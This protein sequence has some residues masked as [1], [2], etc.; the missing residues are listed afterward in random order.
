MV[1]IARASIDKSLIT[2]ILM[3]GCLFGGIWGFATIGRLEDPSFSIKTAIVITQYPGA[4]AEEVA[5][6]VSEPLESAIQQ[7]AE[8][9]SISSTNTRGMSRI[10][11]DVDMSYGPDEIPQIWDKLRDRVRDA[12][13]SLPQD[14]AEPFVNDAFGDVFGLFYAVSA[15]GFSDAEIH[16]VSTFIRRE[17]LVVDGVA[18][19]TLDGLPEE[20]IH[21]EPDLAILANMGLPSSAISEAIASA[22]NLAPAGSVMRSG[23]QT[24][25]SSPRGSDTVEEI[26]TLTIGL[27]GQVVSVQ[28]FANVSRGRVAA[29]TKLIRYQGE[30]VFTLGVSALET[31]N[32]VDVGNRV[33]AR[34]DEIMESLPYGI[35]IHPIYQQ[36]VVVDEASNDFLVNLA[37][38]VLIV[39]VV[40]GLF[41]GWRA[42][43]VVG[44]TLLLTVVGTS[45]FMAIFSIE[46]QRISLGALI[47][48]MGMLVDNAIVVAEGMQGDMAGGK[49][50]RDAAKDVAGKTQIPLLGATVIGI[51]AF[52]GIGLS[53]DAT[54]EFLFSLFAV[55]GISLL[56]SWL[57]AVTV[58]PLLGHYLF[59]QGDGTQGDGYDGMVFRA[60]KSLLRRALGLRWLVVTALIVMTVLSII[61]FGRVTQQFFPPSNTPIFFVHYKLPQGSSLAATA[62]DLAVVEDWLRERP[63][64]VSASTFVGGGASRFMLTYQAEDP[65][66]SYGQVI[67]RT[68]NT[69]VILGL[70]G[71]LEA[72]G[73]ANLP[74]GQFRTEQLVFGPGGGTP[75]QARFSGP[76]PV[77]LRRLGAEAR[78]LMIAHGTDLRNI[79]HDW[80]EQEMVMRPDYATNRA[81]AAGITREDVADTLQMA[82]EGRSVAV[83]QEGA[84][85]IPIVLRSPVP[86]GDRAARLMDEL[87]YSE[88]SESYFPI[89]QV[90]DGFIPEVQ[91]SV[92]ERRDRIFTL[93]VQAGVGPGVN[94]AD[95]LSQI[96]PHLE[97]MS[98]PAGY[99][100]EWGGEYENQQD[101]QAALG[102]VLPVTLLA[103]VLTSVLLFGKL[104]Q[105]LIIWLLVPMAINGTVIALLLTGMPFSFTALLG[106]LSLSGMLI[107]NG[108][109]LVEEIDIVRGEGVPMAEAILQASTSR[110]RPVLLAAATTILGMI[111]LLSDAFFS[112]MAVTIMGGLGF[113][114]I[115]TLIAAPVLY[116][117]FFRKERLGYEKSR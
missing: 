76:D 46:M 2:W 66:P 100:F 62:A 4:S 58:T 83:Y 61:G 84:R 102:G 51:L 65:S 57:L 110:V 101:A 77:V 80:F 78:N 28:D 56:L 10:T 103:M 88:P 52:S 26:S 45:F 9:D 16:D 21:V 87:V 106:L 5:R 35:E 31:L 34:L 71:E 8:V 107:K 93:T 112:S 89:S 24:H 38:S 43:V 17:L 54:G 15:P 22:G 44:T 41:M 47:I 69:D 42:A 115:L 91:N 60:Y 1:S 64:V 3:L 99:R 20:A 79:R 104:R 67:V 48:A 14:A 7:M 82:T 109:V 13:A 86:A 94:A 30:D 114:S 23:L 53:P 63:E 36:H 92:V 111:P 74:N 72:F 50:S 85:Q 95:I 18:N 33:D 105:P 49:T 97:G 19:V 59:R 81:Q 12:R 27:S 11:V 37:M 98:L 113:A 73:A 116:Y 32:V 90:V 117:I 70:R 96:Q 39:V 29:P 75:I 6:E 55:V 108:I 68:T 40:L 25:I